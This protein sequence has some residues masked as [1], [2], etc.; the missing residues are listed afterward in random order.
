[1]D[2]QLSRVAKSDVTDITDYYSQIDEQLATRFVNELEAALGD[3]CL[4]P[5]IGSRRYAH[6]LPDKSLRVWQL[7]R[8]PFLLFYRI[9][10]NS[11]DIL[12]VL[13]ERRD[14][15]ATLIAV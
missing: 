6:F 5:D 9:Q 4:R 7:D 10:D 13:H 8:F 14:L 15:S 1:M 11:L 3:L 2:F 12:R